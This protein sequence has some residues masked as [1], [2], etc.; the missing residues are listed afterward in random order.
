M[1]QSLFGGITGRT[2]AHLPICSESRVSSFLKIGSRGHDV[3]P[4]EL[5]GHSRADGVKSNTSLGWSQEAG[6]LTPLT[7]RAGKLQRG[8]H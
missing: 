3:V 7:V 5:H 1:I 2:N 6:M 4:I 8:T